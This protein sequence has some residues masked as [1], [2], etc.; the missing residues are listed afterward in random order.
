MCFCSELFVLKYFLQLK[1]LFRLLLLSSNRFLFSSHRFL[2]IECNSSRVRFKFFI[3]G[4]TK[5]N[6]RRLW[7]NVWFRTWYSSRTVVTLN[8]FCW[9]FQIVKVVKVAL[10]LRMMKMNGWTNL[11]IFHELLFCLIKLKLASSF[12]LI[13]MPGGGA[14]QNHFKLSNSHFKWW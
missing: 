1:R 10:N 7:I 11:V 3:F 6:A 12:S 14:S 13:C 4:R 5:C 8:C 2:L 9:I